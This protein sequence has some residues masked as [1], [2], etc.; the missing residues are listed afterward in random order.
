MDTGAY[1]DDSVKK[2]CEPL[3]L[4]HVNG[5]GGKDAARLV[6]DFKVN[7]WPT[8]VMLKPSGEVLKRVE[9]GLETPDAFTGKWTGD[10]W[11]AYVNAQN[12]KPQEG[13]AMAENLFLLVTWYSHSEWGKKA[14]DAA[15][16]A[17]GNPD[18]KAAWDDL[19]K[20]HEL[21]NWPLK[22][23]AQLK[24]GK[25]NDAIETYKLIATTYPD[26]KQG[27]DAAAMLK[28]LGVKMDAAPAEKK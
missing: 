22:A 21:E 10:V 16:Q 5:G 2:F 6:K 24:L 18:F 23:D 14:V 1:P 8:L 7:A 13:K 26:E 11:N 28:K 9:G 19:K 4:M 20:K 12:A 15:K 27:K 3:V 17:E 25:K